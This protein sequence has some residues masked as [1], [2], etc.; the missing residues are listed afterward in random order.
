M[1]PPKPVKNAVYA[2]WLCIGLSA[3]AALLDRLIGR[4]PIGEFALTIIVYGVFVMIPYKLARRSNATRFV[5]AVLIAISILYWLG[6]PSLPMPP[7][8]KVVSILQ[9]PILAFSLY[10]LFAT[11]G[12]AHWFDG[13]ADTD[14]DDLVMERIDPKL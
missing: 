14:E 11:P 2:I 5:F 6:A 10:W 13:A 3:F 1:N 9:I 4:M 8:S 7:F 12:A